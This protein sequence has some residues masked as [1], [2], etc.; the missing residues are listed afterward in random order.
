VSA[1]PARLDYRLPVTGQLVT[2]LG[3]VSK[4]GARA[5]GLTLR[6]QGQA[7]VS[8]PHAGRIAFAGPFKGYGKIIIIDHGDGW[9]SLI[10]DMSTLSVRIGETVIQGSPI[11]RTGDGTPKVTIELRRSGRPVDITPMIG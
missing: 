8:A 11:G 2:G 9:T 6:T 7:Q 3:E 10:T 1:S 4:T 5:K